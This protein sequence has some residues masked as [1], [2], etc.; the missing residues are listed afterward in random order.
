MSSKKHPVRKPLPTPRRRPRPRPAVELLEERCLLSDFRTIT[1]FGN[2]QTNQDWGSTNVALLRT[3]PVAYADG[4]DDPVVGS[5][6]RPS[7]RIISNTVVAQTTEERVFS[8]RLMSAMIYGWGQFLDHDLDLT[9]NASP[10]EHFNIPVPADDPV[11]TGDIPFN[12]SKSVYI[13]GVRQQPNEIT[14]FIDASMVYGSDAVR[15]H[16]L[17]TNDGT[18]RLKTGPGNLLPLATTAN[19]PDGVPFMGNDTHA[20]PDDQLFVAGDIRANENIELTSLHTLFV[21]EHNRLAGLIATA[22][23]GMSDEDIYQRARAIVGAEMQVITYNQWIPT[24]LGPN[25]LPAYP[26]YNPNTA[27][28]PGIANEFSTALFRLG[29]SMLGDDVEF[30]GN[31][32]EELDEEIPLHEAFTNPGKVSEEGIDPILKYLASDPSSEVDNTIVD[33]VR[34]LLFNVPGGQIGFDLASLNIQR[35]RDHGLAD[36]NTVRGAYGLS[37]VSSFAQ[38]TPDNGIQRKLHDLYNNVNNIDLWV[39]G[40]AEQHV[41]G[42]STGQLIRTVLINQFTRLR[43]GDRFW[44]QNQSIYVPSGALPSG[45][46]SLG[47]V[48][49]AD[50]IAANTTNT[51]DHLQDNVF[52][53]KP[54][55]SGTV[56]NDTNHDGVRDPGEVP[57]GGRTVQLEDPATGD[58]LVTT[59][60]DSNGFYSFDVFAG[61]TLGQ[62]NVREIPQNNWHVSSPNP[63]LVTLF[64]GDQNVVVDF[65]NMK[66]SALLVQTPSLADAAEAGAAPLTL[67]QLQPLVAEA[68]ARWAAAGFSSKILVGL[69]N[70]NVQVADLPGAVL[71]LATA[72]G[73]MLDHN[74]AGYGWFVDPT[75]AT[76]TEFPAA[77]G[78]PAYG[79]VDLLTVVTH[80][81]GHLLGLEHSHDDG[82]VMAESLAPGVRLTPT[83]DDAGTVVAFG[84]PELA[85]APGQPAA[86]P[87]D[88]PATPNPGSPGQPLAVQSDIGTL[89]YFG[90]LMT[91]SLEGTPV[92]PAPLPSANPDQPV[93]SVSQPPLPV[94]VEGA[95]PAVLADDGQRQVQAARVVDQVFTDLETG[96]PGENLWDGSV[97]ALRPQQ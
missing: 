10:P 90:T 46:A 52:F 23:P 89:A 1:G 57:L 50:V 13:D 32:G 69:T 31:N 27:P 68:A 45:A 19:F 97:P 96:L 29:H 71:G 63:V 40:L 93:P 79:R 22:N 41:P 17:R 78:S 65:G 43:N 24:L 2:N 14:A 15:A 55:I 6:T 59:T 95:A 91:A 8:D 49:L 83:A 47:S 77:P 85:A 44:Y 72:D 39:G 76:D 21:R 62:F 66:D 18:G 33:E 36:Y 73:I 11:F 74:G 20:V 28:N 16:A 7:P 35:G 67:E 34:N 84:V 61:L 80:E 42:T 81:M 38:V 3:A 54:T 75:P 88:G 64:K 26:G 58:V 94:T 53:F 25:A 70:V 12:R 60:T 51:R 37:Q 9:T 56:F 48:T 5:P 82:D 4:I 86:N 87:A 30:I 92:A